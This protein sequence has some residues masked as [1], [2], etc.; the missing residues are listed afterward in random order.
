MTE[1]SRP[2]A[3]SS[4]AEGR[5]L[6]LIVGLMRII[7]G[8]HF[9]Y[10]GLI[11]IVDSKWSAAGYLQSSSGPA[12]IWFKDMAADQAV[13]SVVNQ[14]NIWGLIVIGIC[15]MLGLATRFSAVAGILLLALYYLCHLPFGPERFGALED[16][17]MIV[18]RNLVEL[19]ALCVVVY[20]P[21]SRLGLDGIFFAR[22]SWPGRRKRDAARP[23]D[24]PPTATSGKLTRRQILT[25][26]TGVPFVGG[27]ALAMVKKHTE[28]S[29]KK[30]QLV[31]KLHSD[32]ATISVFF[33]MRFRSLWLL[34][35]WASPVP[36]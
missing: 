30:N 6:T 8:W 23:A 12:A 27:F 11:R 24:G 15:L 29:H 19:L 33:M 4:A 7:I 3:P 20:N 21:A 36:M 22:L 10:E 17:F 28:I 18:N 5:A 25:G 31:L 32:D 9:L 13:L 34:M 14:L 1:T 2:P 26:L 16:H 35:H